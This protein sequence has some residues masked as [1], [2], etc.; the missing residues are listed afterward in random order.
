MP[1]G[2]KWYIPLYGIGIPM[3]VQGL[4]AL[5]M[6]IFTYGYVVPYVR[7]ELAKPTTP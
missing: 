5:A 2:W 6:I 1:K 7:R 3:W 4:I